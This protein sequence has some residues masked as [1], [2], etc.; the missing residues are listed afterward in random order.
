MG[1]FLD[2]IDFAGFA[3]GSQVRIFAELV[4]TGVPNNHFFLRPLVPNVAEFPDFLTADAV[5]T[6]L[7]LFNMRASHHDKLLSHLEPVLLLICVLT[8]TVS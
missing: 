4:D 7:V 5:F 6:L 2:W 1:G 8:N 3:Q